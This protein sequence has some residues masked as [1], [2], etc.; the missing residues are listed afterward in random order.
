MSNIVIVKP[1]NI[2]GFGCFTNTSGAMG[3]WGPILVC[4]RLESEDVSDRSFEQVYNKS[5]N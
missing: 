5:R 4:S 3:I 1:L 2:K